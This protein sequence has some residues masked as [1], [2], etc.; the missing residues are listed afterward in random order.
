MCTRSGLLTIHCTSASSH[1]LRY[2]MAYSARNAAPA[3]SILYMVIY[4]L[5]EFHERGILSFFTRVRTSLNSL[6]VTAISCC[7]DHA[8]D[9]AHSKGGRSTI[10]YDAVPDGGGDSSSA[11]SKALQSGR[12]GTKRVALAFYGLTRSLK[13]TIDSIKLNVMD[14]LKE[15]GYEYDVYLHTYDLKS[16]SNIRSGETGA[17]NT[18]EWKLLT[19]DYVQID[20]QVWDF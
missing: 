15:A 4:T 16:L 9:Q 6:C 10:A 14:Q 8:S 5:N 2:F 11:G 12:T 3:E 18:T 13:Y 17:L 20:D 1:T 7:R 19:P